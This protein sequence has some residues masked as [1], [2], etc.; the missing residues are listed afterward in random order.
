[1]LSRHQTLEHF[2]NFSAAEFDA[3]FGTEYPV[4]AYQMGM[5]R[6]IHGPLPLCSSC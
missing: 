1:M 5:G 3:S 6:A 4:S 2:E